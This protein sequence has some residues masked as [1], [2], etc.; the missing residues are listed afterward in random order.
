MAS[1]VAGVWM[2]DWLNANSQRRYPLHDEATRG[3]EQVLRLARRA[4]DPPLTHLQ[5]GGVGV[6]PPGGQGREQL[7]SGGRRLAHLGDVAWGRAAARGDAV[8]GHEFGV[9][10]DQVHLVH[11]DAE[12]LGRGLRARGLRVQELAQVAAQVRREQLAGAVDVGHG[13]GCAL[14]GGEDADGAADADRR[15]ALAVGGKGSKT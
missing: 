13:D 1:P 2:V 5:G 3:L 12:L 8:V 9:G 14:S 11:R 7:P 4:G 6:P 15:I 10:H